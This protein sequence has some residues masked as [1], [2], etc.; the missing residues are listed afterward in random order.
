[1][2]LD[3]IRS[4]FQ[5]VKNQQCDWYVLRQQFEKSLVLIQQQYK[6]STSPQNPVNRTILLEYKWIAHLSLPI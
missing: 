1:M 3:L 5:V 4:P 2:E 6:C